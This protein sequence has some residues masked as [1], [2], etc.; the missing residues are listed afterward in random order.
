MSETRTI[1]EPL[2]DRLVVRPTGRGGEQVLPSGII[3]PDTAAVQTTTGEVLV[4]GPGAWQD[5]AR[6]P[7]SV[8][9]GD[10]VMFGRYAGTEMEVDGEAVLFL[11]ESDV[12]SVVR[13]E[14][15]G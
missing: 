7:L 14:V 13:Q 11:C 12:L 9:V 2:G 4:V 6:R 1:L 10:V 3:V 8:E 15:V 5:G